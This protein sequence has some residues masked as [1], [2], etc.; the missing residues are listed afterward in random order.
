MA[1]RE[2]PVC[3]TI[4]LEEQLMSGQ[5]IDR[6]PECQGQFYDRG[7]LE[8][9]TDLARVFQGVVLNEAEIPSGLDPNR[10]ARCCPADRTLME[11][12]EAAGVLIDTCGKCGG[13]WLDDGEVVALK[14]AEAHIRAN[15]GL[16]LRLGQ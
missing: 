7:E 15:I 10:G 14:L 9:L 2:C 1:I 3:P 13:I 6:C 12:R 4:Q 5:T 11:E 8:A 16:Y